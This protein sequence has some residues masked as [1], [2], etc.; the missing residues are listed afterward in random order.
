MLAGKFV[1]GCLID[2]TRRPLNAKTPGAHV[3]TKAFMTLEK[4]P[5]ANGSGTS[6]V[7]G[8][9]GVECRAYNREPLYATN[10]TA[11]RAQP[12]GSMKDA[13]QGI[14]MRETM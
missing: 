6:E 14:T 1:V 5:P 2:K 8:T 13:P 3:T 9:G 11:S 4:V 7:E 10:L 12:R